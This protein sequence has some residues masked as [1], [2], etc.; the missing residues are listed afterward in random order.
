MIYYIIRFM[1]ALWILH[2]VTYA[3]DEASAIQVQKKHTYS[4]LCAQIG[5]LILNDATVA[6]NGYVMV[7]N[8]ATKESVR[9]DFFPESNQICHFDKHE[10]YCLFASS[11]VYVAKLRTNEWI[12]LDELAL[13]RVDGHVD[14]LSWDDYVNWLSQLKKNHASNLKCVTIKFWATDTCFLD[15]HWDQYLKLFS[16]RPC[17]IAFYRPIYVYGADKSQFAKVS[18]LDER[19]IKRI[20][21]DIDTCHQLIHESEPSSFCLDDF[22]KRMMAYSQQH[23]EEFL[24]A[25]SMIEFKLYDIIRRGADKE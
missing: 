18:S 14:W 20:I 1:L 2:P 9:I 3:Q 21:D 13:F 8:Q 10:Y 23:P 5:N 6:K 24:H 4:N 25:L 12:E 16:M 15:E 11:G 7:H 19:L 22:E 17:F